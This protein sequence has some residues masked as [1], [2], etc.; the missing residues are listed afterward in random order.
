MSTSK[1]PASD[2]WWLDIP[3]DWGE[4]E[5]GV[6]WRK[7]QLDQIN[8]ASKWSV[9]V[10]GA[11]AVGKTHLEGDAC[12]WAVGQGKKAWFINTAGEDGYAT[13]VG[14]RRP[15]RVHGGRRPDPR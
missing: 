9:L 3:E 14:P 12:R 8:P 5:T 7:L 4:R 13:L 1:S 11:N 2:V 10:Y 6:A 15:R